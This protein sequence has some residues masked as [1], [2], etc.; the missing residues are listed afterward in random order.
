M[1]Y[2]PEMLGDHLAIA[3][4][5]RTLAAEMA[6]IASPDRPEEWFVALGQ[7]TFEHVDRTKNPALNPAILRDA[8]EAAYSSLRMIFDPKGFEV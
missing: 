6:R 7:K 2:T 1:E 4:C 8:K 3:A 5:I